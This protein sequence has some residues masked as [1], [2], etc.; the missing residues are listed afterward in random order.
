M[1]IKIWK[2]LNRIIRIL[3][4]LSAFILVLKALKDW[5]VYTVP[6]KFLVIALLY[7]YLFLIA[8]GIVL[9]LRL[10]LRL[11]KLEEYIGIP[12]EE[13]FK[14]GLIRWDFEG[15]W[16]I[17]GKGELN[18]TNSSFGGITRVGHLWAD[19]TFEFDGVILNLVIA[20][21]VRAQDRFSYYMIQ[22]DS[23]NVVPHLFFAGRWLRIVSRPHGLSLHHN[24]LMRIK[25]EVRGLSIRIWVDG[26][27]IYHEPR[28]F[29]MRFVV[30]D[31]QNASFWSPV[32]PFTGQLVP[33][34]TTGRVGFREDGLE[35]GRFSNCKV[36]PI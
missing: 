2:W 22:L 8:F 16:T 12:F 34:F 19:Y 32:P 25:T 4:G 9:I 31:T 1:Q 28:L 23:T 35:H 11:R 10:H 15:D 21:I 29:D 24:Q 14:K 7:W 5:G 20:W 30:P 33:P 26:K 18:V 3:G 27:E 13:K 17:T 6:W 36:I